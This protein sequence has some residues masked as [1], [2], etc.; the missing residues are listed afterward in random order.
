[1]T[2]SSAPSANSRSIRRLL[3]LAVILGLAAASAAAWADGKGHGVEVLLVSPKL[4][5]AQ[6][7]QVV[8]LS[9]RVTNTTEAAEGLIESLRLPK[10]WQSITPVAVLSL[11]PR[12]AQVQLVAV[13]VP[14]AA[15]PGRYDL[16]YAVRDQRD[17]G[18]QDE[19]STTVAVASL[20]RL[21]LLLEAK[22]DFVIAGEAYQV[23]VRVANRGNA[24]AHVS[25]TVRSEQGCPATVSPA[26]VD[27]P[28]GG[29]EVAVV[30]VKT[31]AQERRPRQNALQV[32]STESEGGA[33]GVSLTACVDIVPRVTA[34]V[35][36]ERRLPA[37]VAVQIAGDGSH[38]GAQIEFSGSGALS[39]SRPDQLSF[40]LRGPDTGSAGIFGLRDEYRVGYSNPWL[41]ATLGDQT[42]SL[43]ALTDL[44]RYGRGVSLDARPGHGL[45]AGAYW[46]ASRFETPSLTEEGGHVSC[47]VGPHLTA[48]LNFLAAN[49][50]GGAAPRIWSAETTFRP[51]PD[52]TLAMEFGQSHVGTEGGIDDTA[53]RIVADTK[54]AR[55][56]L[57]SFSKTH[58]GPDYAGYYTDSDYTA[59]AATFPLTKR[60]AVRASFGQLAQ[61]LERRPDRST[62]PRESLDEIGADYTLSHHWYAAGEY[63][64][65]A[66]HDLLAVADE[67]YAEQSVKLSLGYN[68]GRASARCELR[69]GSQSGAAWAGRSAVIR[70]TLFA[71]YRPSDALALSVSGSLG[72]GQAAPQSRLFDDSNSL[73]LSL[74]WKLSRRTALSGSYLRCDQSGSGPGSQQLDFRATH[75][76][77]NGTSWELRVLGSSP[78]LE[79]NPGICYLV[80]YTVPFGIPL[81]ARTDIGGLRGR[82]YDAEQPGRPGVGNV[83]LT[84]SGAAAV[85]DA[86]GRFAFPALAPGSYSVRVDQRSIGLTR[87]VSGKTPVLVEVKGGAVQE[88]S[89]GIV[90]A[91]A[92]SGQVVVLPTP[93]GNGA[94]PPAGGQTLRD[95]SGTYVV[96]GAGGTSPPTG[97]VGLPGTL[98]ELTE[99]GDVRRT[100]TDGAGRFAFTGL[101]PATWHLKVYDYNLPEFHRLDNPERDIALQGGETKEVTVSVLPRVRRIKMV[102]GADASLTDESGGR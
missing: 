51:L 16:G 23:T 70:S 38:A 30:S 24:R 36:L 25:L 62:A 1:M 50:V 26:V 63:D 28:A 95:Q 56:G 78:A 71:T 35:D 21:S 34:P 8:S 13:T 60:L 46:L 87:V 69:G 20:S 91:A 93:D 89:V 88:V 12:E 6:P 15:G 55:T 85:T 81:G 5:E 48:R 49:P 27:L 39:S 54:L 4:V 37:T 47:D 84:V 52:T 79:G 98:V 83:V 10:G 7:G 97:A 76:L 32:A 73:A 44:S 31:S 2:T 77:A 61:N 53:Y 65:F 68:S 33:S 80:G 29:S 19:D 3:G 66:H 43:S 100:A 74:D 64:H 92:L 82:V 40:L 90:K 86:A 94:S 72:N 99:G 9:L 75:T 102:G 45:E 42:C 58:A 41:D 101:R 14:R 67:Q 11:A 59:A 22:P 57:L 17:Y 18:I 96:G